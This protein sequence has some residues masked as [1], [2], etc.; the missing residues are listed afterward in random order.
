MA[1]VTA[2]FAQHGAAALARVRR[3][4]PATYLRIVGN[5]VPRELVVQREREPNVDIENLSLAE[6]IELVE[7]L[8]R[9][10]NIRRALLEAER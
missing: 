8:E 9:Q 7:R 10:K 1:T 3:D 6:F 4:D 2:D 5:F